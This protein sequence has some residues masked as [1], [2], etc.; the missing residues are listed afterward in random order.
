VHGIER[1]ITGGTDSPTLA[2]VF[3]PSSDR[4][5]TVALIGGS[6]FAIAILAQIKVGPI[7]LLPLAVL[8]AAAA[9][10]SRN[11]ALASGVY[12]ALGM[13]GL[14]VFGG[15][16]SAWSEVE[17][18]GPFAQHAL[19]YLAGLVAAA[20]AV[21]WL[22]E[23]RWWD[24]KIPTAALL[25]LIGVLIIYVPGRLWAEI[26][27]LFLRSS[28]AETSVLPSIPMLVITVAV[29]AVALPQAWAWVRERQRSET[30]VE[31][32]VH[33]PATQELEP[34]PRT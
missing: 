12:V 5:A 26:V 16:H 15:R 17:Y 31:P 1:W 14:P 27:A 32:Q 10:G 25:A 28:R 4:V 7:W 8:L 22:A 9:L 21:G 33:E 34:E 18:Q 20:Y 6:A 2:E 23:R 3:F 24:R 11:G 13:I 30:T 19:G 29:F